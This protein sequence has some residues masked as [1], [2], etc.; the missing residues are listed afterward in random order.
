MFFKRMNRDQMMMGIA[1]VVRGRSTCLRRQV[2][3]V[4]ARDSHPVTTGYVG[5][6]PGG[7]HC[8]DVGCLIDEEKKV[9]IRTIHAE[10][11]AISFAARHGIR[12]EDCDLFSTDEPCLSCAKAIVASGIK[13]VVYLDSY[14]D[15]SGTNFLLENEVEVVKAHDP[16]ETKPPGSKKNLGRIKKR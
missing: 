2:G 10:I 14:H 3:V 7:S 8:L 1:L 11:N 6:R 9:C 4:I 5:S 15:H 13:K 16:I 12:I